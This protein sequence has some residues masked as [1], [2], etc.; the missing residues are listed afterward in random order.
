MRAETLIPPGVVTICENGI[1]IA[2]A[3]VKL[4]PITTPKT[5]LMACRKNLF[6]AS[7]SDFLVKADS[8]LSPSLLFTLLTLK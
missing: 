8:Y 7:C 5:V 3:C 6:S 2:E 4:I 1:I